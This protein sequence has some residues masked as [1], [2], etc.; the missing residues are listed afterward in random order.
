MEAAKSPNMDDN[1]LIPNRINYNFDVKSPYHVNIKHR[2]YKNTKIDHSIQDDGV[3][4]F[5]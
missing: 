4:Y 2:R 1:K 3:A 5:S